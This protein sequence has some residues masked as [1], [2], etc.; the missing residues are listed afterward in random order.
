M[1]S[2]IASIFLMQASATPPQSPSLPPPPGC[3]SAEFAAF[4]FWLGE[5]DVYPSG[6]ENL[7]AHSRI[8]KL[9][10]GCAVRENWMPLNGSGGG[11]LNGY[12]PQT[13]LWR[14]FWIG[15]A[16]GPVEFVGG[17]AGAGMA[18]TGYWQGFGPNGEDAMVRQTFTPIDGDTVRQHGEAS[19]DHGLTWSTRYDLTYRR[20]KEPLE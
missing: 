13:G 12:Y 1:F 16:P 7:V 3:N 9:Y 8:E 6:R 4:D 14:Q 17:P 20:R 19:F 5:W 11:S 18:M 10:L 2:I 15:A